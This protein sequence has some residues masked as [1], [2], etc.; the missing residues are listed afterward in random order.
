MSNMNLG[1]ARV[2]AREVAALDARIL[3][4]VVIAVAGVLSFV[5]FVVYF[6]QH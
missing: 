1:T 3:S 2:E 6:I 5:P 4:S